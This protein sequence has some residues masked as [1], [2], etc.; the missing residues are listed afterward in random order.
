MITL[1][2]LR[3]GRMPV[4]A[5]A[6]AKEDRK[7]MGEGGI[8]ELLLQ[9]K[10]SRDY[11]FFVSALDKLRKYA[12]S[13]RLIPGT[14]LHSHMQPMIKKMEELDTLVAG[15]RAGLPKGAKNPFI[16]SQLRDSLADFADFV[17][18]SIELKSSE[19]RVGPEE[20][21]LLRSLDGMYRHFGLPE[22]KNWETLRKAVKSMG[23]PVHMDDGMIDRLQLNWTRKNLIAQAGAGSRE[24]LAN[25]ENGRAQLLLNSRKAALEDEKQ[26][27]AG[28]RIP[29]SPESRP[30]LLFYTLSYELAMY[31]LKYKKE[32]DPE[33]TKAMRT[34]LDEMVTLDDIMAGPD[35]DP[36]A[37]EPNPEIVETCLK[38]KTWPTL[39]RY[40][41][42]FNPT[43]MVLREDARIFRIMY[44][45]QNTLA[46]PE[47]VDGADMRKVYNYTVEPDSREPIWPD[48]LKQAHSVWAKKLHTRTLEIDEKARL[49]EERRLA[50][51][52]EQRRKEADRRQMKAMYK[53]VRETE[54][55]REQKRREDFR[56][57]QEDE[58]SQAEAERL[59][60]EAEA[61]KAD[62][63]EKE[64]QRL[65]Q[66]EKDAKIEIPMSEWDRIEQDPEVKALMEESRKKH[67][68][69]LK[70]NPPQQEVKSA[71][72]VPRCDGKTWGEFAK[73]LRA[74]LQENV[75]YYDGLA[76]HSNDPGPRDIDHIGQ[77]TQFLVAEGRYGKAHENEI[78]D[79]RELVQESNRL[80]RDPGF[81]RLLKDPEFRDLVARKNGKAAWERIVEASGE[82]YAKKGQA[83]PYRFTVTELRQEVQRQLEIKQRPIKTV[84]D[85]VYLGL[86]DEKYNA[87]VRK[88]GFLFFKPSDTELYQT[89]VSS[90]ERIYR[91][92]GEYRNADL[93]DARQALRAYLDKR[94]DVRS[95]EYGR[96]RWEKLMC[97]YK[98]LEDPKEFEDY[99][100]ELNACRGFTDPV[101]DATDPDYVHP[102][103]FG[104]ERVDLNNP[105]VPMNE[106]YRQMRQDYA[107][108]NAAGDKDALLRYY[109]RVAAMR[110]QAF[111]KG[112][113]GQ[114]VQEDPET[115]QRTVKGDWGL[116]ID[117]EQ[118]DAQAKEL[119]EDYSFR[120]ALKESDGANREALFKEAYR[121]LKPRE[122]WMAENLQPEQREKSEAEKAKG[123][124]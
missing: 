31:Y 61:R 98:A 85:S 41:G 48:A 70:N 22:H 77:I 87:D 122:D 113:A 92:T 43:S 3:I 118:V 1:D 38:E 89:A 4:E 97:A 67:E 55:D 18:T 94:K 69:E 12:G 21:E 86:T 45:L 54:R 120:K 90:L 114:K 60:A 65:L 123:I 68:E 34:M 74:Y 115:G 71:L 101:K 79:E 104:P 49:A 106:A 88:T 30:Y 20:T 83:T 11:L 14:R 33:S 121:I 2:A 7:K 19:F 52:A 37:E 51:E 36:Q 96:R 39:V 29:D 28:K 46:L 95:H 119:Y 75:S 112:E 35:S 91:T 102:S 25:T 64:R 13:D 100:A 15:E 40:F 6:R 105:H 8:T 57:K 109:A 5:M 72:P 32:M 62:E 63:E 82:E 103:A 99:C 73:E 23:D 66:E 24:A 17:A 53:L 27:Q 78:V 50:E 108:A 111:L 110:T 10:E 42:S 80:I 76:P 81:L 47:Q 44:E 116:L 16:F 9:N 59:A 26:R 124:S 117:M 58:K 107:K 56:K 93:G 84:V